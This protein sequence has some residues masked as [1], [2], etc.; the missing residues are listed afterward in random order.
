MDFRR[1][2]KK[3]R[4]PL[5]LK[6]DL[7]P[8]DLKEDLEPVN[9]KEGLETVDLKEDLV[10]VN[11]EEDSSISTPNQHTGFLQQL[12]TLVTLKCSKCV[13]IKLTPDFFEVSYPGKYDPNTEKL[14]ISRVPFVGIKECESYIHFDNR[15]NSGLGSELVDLVNAI[16]KNKGLEFRCMI[17]FF[18]NNNFTI[19]V[20]RSYDMNALSNHL[21]TKFPEAVFNLEKMRRCNIEVF[22]ELD[23][24][25][26]DD[27]SKTKKQGTESNRL[28]SDKLAYIPKANDFP[29]LVG[30]NHAPTWLAPSSAAF[31]NNVKHLQIAP[32]LSEIE[33][34]KKS[35]ICYRKGFGFVEETVIVRTTTS[36]KQIDSE[37]CRVI[38]PDGTLLF[39]F[40]NKDG[41]FSYTID[42]K[43]KISVSEKTPLFFSDI[44]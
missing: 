44:A 15:I 30:I 40:R 14:A 32:A 25:V 13:I 29:S 3:D 9:L 22:K 43:I 33:E 1:V 10:S 23:I 26:K 17:A 36:I 12:V 21:K 31:A 4:T 2:Y 34:K 28:V 8:V 7:E 39:L 20:Y 18:K 6:E 35:S 41:T 27:L 42:G 16:F 38:G 24:H 37:N 19:N 5:R 11:L